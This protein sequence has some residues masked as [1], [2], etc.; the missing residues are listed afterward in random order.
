MAPVD[1][2]QFYDAD[3]RRRQSEELEFGNDWRE[4]GAR[5]QVAWVEATGEIY[6]MRD[7]LGALVADVIG[8]TRAS[9]VTDEDLTVEVL[10]TIDGRDKIAAV[11]SGWD[12]AMT[13]GDNSLSWV[14]DRIANADSELGDAPAKPSRDLPPA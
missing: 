12:T 1:L 5:T 2:E 8:D 7:P 14:R 11:M 6:A 10:G 9:P 4:N 3:P 13:A